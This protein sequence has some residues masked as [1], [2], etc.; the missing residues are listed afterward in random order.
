MMWMLKTNL[1]VW[2]PTRYLMIWMLKA[3]FDGLDA[4]DAV[5]DQKVA[6]WG[7]TVLNELN[8]SVPSSHVL[9]SS[10]VSDRQNLSI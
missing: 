3:H 2:I 5:H 10:L 8:I 4:D 9:A 1:M 6:L 7:P